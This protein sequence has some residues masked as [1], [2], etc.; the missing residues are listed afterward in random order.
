MELSKIKLLNYILITLLLSVVSVTNVSA[1]TTFFDQDDA[2]IMGNPTT[3]GVIDGTTGGGGCTY[4]WNCTNWSECLQS[5]KQIRNCANIGTC[6]DTYE[7]PEIEHNCTYTAS[8]KIT[9]GNETCDSS[10]NCSTCLNDC[11]ACLSEKA[12][13]GVATG[14][15]DGLTTTP[16]ESG[17]IPILAIVGIVMAAY[18]ATLTRS[19]QRGKKR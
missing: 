15:S 8:E 1:E 18:F 9:C 17:I 14:K 2:F 3:G 5:E 11:G 10:E 16:L 6:S 7:P 13:T 12:I 4:R 19:K